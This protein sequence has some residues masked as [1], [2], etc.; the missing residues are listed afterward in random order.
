MIAFC[1]HEYKSFHSSINLTQLLILYISVSRIGNQDSTNQHELNRWIKM[2]YQ[3]EWPKNYI[4]G[5]SPVP[6][7]ICLFRGIA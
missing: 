5:T 6:K 2:K 3:E 4:N 1:V 7:I